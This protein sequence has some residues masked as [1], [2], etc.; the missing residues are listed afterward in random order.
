MENQV[1][2]INHF[3]RENSCTYIFLQNH[4]FSELLFLRF[5]DILDSRFDNFLCHLQQD[6]GKASKGRPCCIDH[7]ENIY[8][9]YR[10][11]ANAFGGD[12]LVAITIVVI[13]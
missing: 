2:T 4:Q 10:G 3:W 9:V 7:G 13:R 1:S 8:K 5:T 6:H 12:L 11:I